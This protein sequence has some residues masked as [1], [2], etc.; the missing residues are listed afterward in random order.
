MT[1]PYRACHCCG[2]IHH[3]PALNTDERAVCTR[4]RSTI[5][6]G[7]SS[8]VGAS[9]TAAAAVAA[10]V[11]FWPAV[12]LPI[13]EVEQ[14]GQHSEQSILTGTIGLFRH[15]SYFVGGVVLLFSIIF[16]LAKIVLL[17]E[18]SLLELLHRKHKALTLRAMEHLGRW[19]MMDVMLLAFLVMLVKLGDLVEFHFGSAVIAFTLC[20]VMSMIA[21][22]SFDPHSIWDESYE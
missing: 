20:V 21:S 14:L 17:I 4:C 19:S 16:P 13:L 8:Q 7:Q 18:L 10:F 22:L 2:L 1:Q 3:V 15:G 11:L 9:R 6:T 5:S 12:L